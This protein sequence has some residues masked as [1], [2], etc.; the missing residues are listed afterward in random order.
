M[1]PAKYLHEPEEIE[2]DESFFM[3]NPDH[4]IW[5]W[6]FWFLFIFAFIFLGVIA[7]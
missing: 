1:L 6:V 4:P 5:P 3:L 7:R 2:V